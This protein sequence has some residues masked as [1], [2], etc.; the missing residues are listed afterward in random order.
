LKIRPGDPILIDRGTE[1]QPL[2]GKVRLMEPSAFTK[3]SALGV[4]EQRVNAIGDFGEAHRLGDAYRVD[5]KIVVWEG[6]EILQ[7]PWSALFR[8]HKTNWCTFIVNHGKVQQQQVSIGQRSDLAAEIRQGVKQGDVVIL[9][10]TEQLKTG[11]R[12]SPR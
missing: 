8:C 9:H 2:R 6:K 12:V 4:E 1:A 7:V 10:P 11:D 5:V 3:I